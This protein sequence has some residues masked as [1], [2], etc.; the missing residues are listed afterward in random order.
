M[1][2]ELSEENIL[3]LEKNA[4]YDLMRGKS[5]NRKIGTYT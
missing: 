4:I 1:I 3:K 2:N 5:Y